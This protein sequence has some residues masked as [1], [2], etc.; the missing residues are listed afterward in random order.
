MGGMV[1]A[2]RYLRRLGAHA[3]IDPVERHPAAIVSLVLYVIGACSLAVVARLPGVPHRHVTVMLVLA[4]LGA[5]VQAPVSYLLLN[6]LRTPAWALHVLQCVAL[7]TVATAVA[8]SGGASSPFWFYVFIPAVFCAYFYGRPVAMTYLVG[9]VLTQALPFF[10]DHRGA[11]GLF[12]AQLV[13]AAPAYLALGFTITTGKRRIW[14]MRSR[15]EML[16][17]EQSAQRRVATAVAGG[18]RAEQIYDMV[19]N[20]VAGLLRCSGA[21]ILRLQDETN[22]VVVGAVGDHEG[23]AYTPG[24]IVPARPGSDV[25]RALRT[26]R[27]VRVAEHGEGTPVA[28]LGYRATI[29]APVRMG[30]RTWGLLAVAAS[31]ADAFTESDEQ[32]LSEFGDLLATAIASAEERA[33]LAEQ[34]LSDSLTGLAN[35]RALQRRLEAELARASRHGSPLSIAM[36]DIDHFKEI[37]DNAGHETGDAMLGR[38]ATALRSFARAEDTLAR[39]GGDEFAWVLPDTTREQALVAVERARRLIAAATPDP[40]R[41]T[42][43]AGICDTD[44]A[45]DASELTRRAD[46]ALYWSKAHGRNQTWIYDPAVVDE[47]TGQQRAERL[48]RSQAIDGLRALVRTREARDGT[49]REHSERVASLARKLARRAGWERSDTLLLGDAALLH[50][51]GGIARPED[52]AAADIALGESDF[53]EL[54]SAAALSARIV[55]GVLDPAQVRWIA[56]QYA[57]PEATAPLGGGALLAVADAWDTLTAVHPQ[58]AEQAIAACERLAGVHLDERAVDLLLELHRA[59]ELEPVVP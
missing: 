20:E 31:E 24:T 32:T 33:T 18:C 26:G 16:A 29:V 58:S 36:I 7:A 41:I 12:T 6:N 52:A 21:G 11:H 14:V 40:Y 27:P 43:S 56:D 9:C 22:L 5:G 15:A 2:R 25:E 51:I 45:A 8:A 23:G 38:V 57:P 19:A 10:Y 46:S 47:L 59:G 30:E 4:L 50:E 3:T 54:K 39:V 48:E 42:I 28:A 55:D 17:A 49:S 35:Q 13:T 53:A 1:G 34:A 44:S 37:N